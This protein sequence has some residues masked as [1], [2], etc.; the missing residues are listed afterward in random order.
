VAKLARAAFGILT[1]LGLSAGSAAAATRKLTPAQIAACD[2]KFHIDVNGSDAKSGWRKPAEGSCKVQ[3]RNGHLF[4]DPTCTPGA[5]NPSVKVSVL[6]GSGFTTQCV[7][8]QASGSSESQKSIVFKWYGI[9]SNSTCEKDHFVPLEAGGADTLDN[10]WPQC[11]PSGATGAK[12][13]FRQKDK[14]EHYL[15]TQ[16][17]A[18]MSQQDMEQGIRT[19]W[20]QYLDAAGKGKTA[21]AKPAKAAKRKPKK[22]P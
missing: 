12:V 7:R 11:G 17:K 5:L 20:T 9:S 14:V 8:N 3:E 19:D 22:K 18:G 15:A 4:P 6:K 16:V 13:Y 21:K 1:C 10:I 2:K